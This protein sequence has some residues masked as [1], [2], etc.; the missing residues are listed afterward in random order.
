[1]PVVLV[2]LFSVAVARRRDSEEVRPKFRY[3]C[4]VNGKIP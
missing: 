3:G 4:A 2:I 1:M